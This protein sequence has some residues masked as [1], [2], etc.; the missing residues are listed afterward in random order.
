MAF[1]G[2]EMTPRGSTAFLRHFLDKIGFSKQVELCPSLPVQ[3]SNR[4]HDVASLLEVVI[5]SI[6]CGANR[7]LTTEVMR[8]DDALRNIFGWKAV[9]VQDAYKRFFNK[10]N[11]GTNASVNQHF[12]SWIMRYIKFNHF[13]LDFDS[14]SITRYGNQDGAKRGYNFVASILNP[15]TVYPTV[16]EGNRRGE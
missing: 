16:Y 8:S 6:W 12:Y 1:T 15:R 3:V 4:G 7:L 14:S 5:A 11:Q 9:P 13:T 2:K 10:L